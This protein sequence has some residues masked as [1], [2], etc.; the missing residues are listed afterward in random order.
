MTKMKIIISFV[1]I[2]FGYVATNSIPVIADNDETAQIPTEE[3]VI[4]DTENDIL[5][6]DNM[7]A[8]FGIINKRADMA[9]WRPS[10]GVW[11]VKTS[12]SNW[13]Q[14]FSRQ[15]GTSG[16][17]PLANTDFDGN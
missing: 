5:Q 13:N 1:L 6:D 7:P 14:S 2:W 3:H 11:Y 17:I 10:S 15:W 9:V 4:I 16:D 8:T 12:G